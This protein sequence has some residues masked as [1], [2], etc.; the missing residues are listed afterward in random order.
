MSVI[1]AN[2]HS[3][4]KM[5]P[6]LNSIM[7]LPLEILFL[8]FQHL[9]IEE[10]MPLRLVSRSWKSLL[11][12]PAVLR[13]LNFSAIWEEW[14]H[15]HEHYVDF[16]LAHATNVLSLRFFQ[17]QLFSGWGLKE[18]SL[19]GKFMKLKHLSRWPHG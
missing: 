15:W 19:D 10:R 6:F 12:H 1:E 4:E 18:A 2:S 16:A 5:R 14:E 8:I 7:N 3:I 13:H 17:C 11:F 9:S